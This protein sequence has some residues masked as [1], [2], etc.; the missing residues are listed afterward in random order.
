MTPREKRKSWNNTYQGLVAQ[1][2]C[3]TPNPD[4]NL[5]ETA[6]WFSCC[7]T[8]HASH[9]SKG[10]DLDLP[11]G[12]LPSFILGIPVKYFGIVCTVLFFSMKPDSLASYTH[13]VF[14]GERIFWKMYSQFGNMV[15][16]QGFDLLFP[17]PSPILLRQVGL[18]KKHT[19]VTLHSGSAQFICFICF[20]SLGVPWQQQPLR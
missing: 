16:F 5:A 14:G 19:P 8:L 10:L 11:W 9:G 2:F 17:Y 18:P 13:P 15:S 6:G 12:W 3:S 1:T 7:E 4:R 20:Q